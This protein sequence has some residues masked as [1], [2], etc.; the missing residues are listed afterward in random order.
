MHTDIKCVRFRDIEY[1]SSYVEFVVQDGR[2]FRLGQG[3]GFISLA[4]QLFNAGRTM[5]SS[6]NI[7]IEELLP[8]PTTVSN[9]C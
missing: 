5:S 6:S 1:T 7:A 3:E 2:A 8:D 4:K 9:I